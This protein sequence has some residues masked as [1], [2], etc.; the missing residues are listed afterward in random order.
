MDNKSRLNYMQYCKIKK[1]VPTI[2]GLKM[3]SV[4]AFIGGIQWV[5]KEYFMI[6]SGKLNILLT[7]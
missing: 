4:G 5:E 1:L 7:T 3:W 6:F 2:E